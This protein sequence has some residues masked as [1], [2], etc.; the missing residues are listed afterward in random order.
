MRKILGIIAVLTVCGF[1]TGCT[2]PDNATRSYSIRS[3]QGPL[4]LD[5]LQRVNPEVYGV[6]VD[7]R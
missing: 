5:D 7:P 2:N 4:P 3:Y 6:P 1:F